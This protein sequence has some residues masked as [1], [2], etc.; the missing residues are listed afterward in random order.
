MSA[1]DLKRYRVVAI[2][3]MSHLAFI[4]ATTPEDAEIKSRELFATNAEHGEFSFEDSGLDG[5]Q[6]EEE[7]C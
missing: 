7:P 5:F 6:I 1:P 2:E 3:W 4:E